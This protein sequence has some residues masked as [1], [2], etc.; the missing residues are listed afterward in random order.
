M[1]LVAIA[2]SQVAAMAVWFSATAVLPALRA[3]WGLSESEA[4]WITASV[5]AGFALGALT[6][7]VLQLADRFDARRLFALC[8]LGAA[9]CTWALTAWPQNPGS[10]IALR[11]VTGVLLAGVYPPGMKLA[12]SHASPAVRGTA[13]GALVAAL[14]LGSALPHAV[15]WWFGDS[16]VGGEVSMPWRSVLRA[17]SAAS[18]FAACV[19]LAFVRLGPFATHPAPFRWSRVRSVLADGR[20]LRLNAAYCGHM[21]E[22][23]ALWSW[24]GAWL[25][26]V[27][28]SGAANSETN[29][30]HDGSRLGVLPQGLVL[31]LAIGVAG[32]VGAF[33]AGPW[34]D[35]LGRR[36]VA[37]SA[38]L[39]S[40]A[41]CLASPFVPAAPLV[42]LP[43]L[44]LWGRA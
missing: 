39:I 20:L 5:Q 22:L 24:L 29:S 15:G 37:C 31:F 17:S 32:S 42:L 7:G 38:M 4:A 44:A 23:Y 1:Q 16:V 30:G 8:A 9:A 19:M 14:T 25:A 13:I 28:A 35:R 40:G 2:L 33:V 10:A 6:S 12:A 3:A 21:W 26:A 34:A 36:V 41:C 27:L 11:F 18:V 43:F